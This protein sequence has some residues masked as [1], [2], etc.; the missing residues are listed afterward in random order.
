MSNVLKRIAFIIISAVLIFSFLSSVGLAS[1]EKQEPIACITKDQLAAQQ[2]IPELISGDAGCSLCTATSICGPCMKKHI[3][4]FLPIDISGIPFTTIV[5]EFE[6]VIPE[7]LFFRLYFS[8]N[9]SEGVPDKNLSLLGYTVAGTNMT[10]VNDSLPANITA[11]YLDD[12]DNYHVKDITFYRSV[13]SS[14]SLS[15]NLTAAIVFLA[16]LVLTLCLERKLHYWAWLLSMIKREV[17]YTRELFL[18]ASKWR[19]ALHAASL[20]ATT[21]FFGTVTVFLLFDIY[22]AN[23]LIA[24]FFL[25][26][27]AA[28]LQ[29]ADRLVSGKGASAARLFLITA[30]LLGIMTAA[31]APPRTNTAWDDGIHFRQAYAIATG[32]TGSSVAEHKYF[33]DAYRHN[34]YTVSPGN[35]YI[36]SPNDYARKLIA[37]D[38]IELKFDLPNDNLTNLIGH[39]PMAAVFV[40][41]NLLGTNFIKTTVLCRLANLIVYTAILYLAIR[42]LKRGGLIFAAV[43][44]LSC[45]LYL[46]CSFKVD[47]W[48]IAWFAYGFA[49]IFSVYQEKDRTFKIS[50]MVLILISFFVGCTPKMVYFPIMLPLLFLHKHK[51]ASPTHQK[52]FR[53]A[54]IGTMVL[55]IALVAI[56]GLFNNFY[57]DIRASGNVSASEQIKFVLKHPFIYFRIFINFFIDLIS[58]N[59][60]N[61]WNT[62]FS[63]GYLSLPKPTGTWQPTLALLLL[64]FAVCFDRDDND[65]YDTKE[66]CHLR[67]GLLASCLATTLMIVTS[68]YI[69]FTPIA[70]FGV[71]GVQFRYLYPLFLPA[72]YAFTPRKI[73]VGGNKNRQAVILFTGICFNYFVGFLQAYMHIF[74]VT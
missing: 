6:E 32:G 16:V 74:M 49:T 55:L 61:T 58:L 64:A 21:A 46:A 39:L 18:S 42:K 24:I 38:A 10:I 59:T 71:A 5:I 12:Y 23:M 33:T 19:F 27:A 53:L 67:I 31:I 4:T 63:Y 2:V 73:R 29:L 50:E 36:Y 43:A 44:L 47:F 3:R 28:A 1:K 48:M 34:A 65:L 40:T 25:S 7:S 11:L 57:T 14:V 8:S 70:Y 56:P 26:I 54:T 17:A 41:S 15:F 45:P 72:L 20:A 68:M 69:T 35:S 52:R 13:P 51:F 22:Q 9:G 66:H 60:W 37:E 62:Q 30:L